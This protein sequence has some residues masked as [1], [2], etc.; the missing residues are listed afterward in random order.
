MMTGPVF[1][2]RPALPLDFVSVAEEIHRIDNAKWWLD[3]DTGQSIL[4]TRNRGDLMMLIVTE[5]SE[6]SEG[7]SGMFDDKLPHLPM[8]DCELADAAIRTFDLLGAELEMG[9]LTRETAAVLLDLAEDFE[10][11]IRVLGLNCQLMLL[12]NRVSAAKEAERK[13]RWTDFHMALGDVLQGIFS[14]ASLHG[15]DLWSVIQAKRAF[16]RVRVDHSVE[17]RRRADG[18]K[19]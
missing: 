7:A 2:C 19:S 18:K 17:H 4:A 15:I 11:A 14:L 12:V 5:L 10:P 16:N 9:R 8:F 3:L 13:Q 1:D 6:A